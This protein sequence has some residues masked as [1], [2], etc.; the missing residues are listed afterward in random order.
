MEG[1]PPCDGVA[2]EGVSKS[3]LLKSGPSYS[4]P[5]KIDYIERLG[6]QKGYKI[7]LRSSQRALIQYMAG[8]QNRL[9]ARIHELTIS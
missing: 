4:S 2:C 7:K 8:N 6:L 3:Q 9:K 1:S 5:Q